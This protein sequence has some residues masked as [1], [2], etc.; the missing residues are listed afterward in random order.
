MMGTTPITRRRALALAGGALAVPQLARGAEVN[1]PTRYVRIIVPFPPGGAAEALARILGERLSHRWGQ[2]VV[3][4]GRPGAGTTIAASYVATQPPDGY[5]LY[6]SPGGSHAVAASLYGPLS[7]DP[8]RSFTAIALIATQPYIIATGP[9]SPFRTL[10]DFI[11]AARARPGALTYAS[12]G[13]GAAPHLAMELLKSMANIDVLH[14]PFNGAGP[15]ATAMVG[16]HVDVVAADGSLT[17]TLRDG[18]L[19][20]LAVTTPQRWPLLPELQA[21]AEVAPE[22]AGYDMS[23]GGSLFA[24]AGLAPEITV[25][26]NRDVIDSLKDPEARRALEVAGYQPGAPLTPE[27]TRD[28]TAADVR[29]YGDLVRKIGLARN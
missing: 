27:Q 5:T 6:N 4:E 23:G 13:V 29:K 15:A 20:G 10:G 16:G 9:N 21:V 18:T 2:P 11:A 22:L 25:K 3:V 14:V 12:T 26:I 8:V 7:Y 17:G 19:R 24:P 1:W 28:A